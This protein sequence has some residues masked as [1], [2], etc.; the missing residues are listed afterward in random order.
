MKTKYKAAFSFSGKYW[1][2]APIKLQYPGNNFFTAE[3]AEQLL[4]SL[5]KAI[6]KAKKNG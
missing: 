3:E 2:D 5:K 6:K 4:K 1:D